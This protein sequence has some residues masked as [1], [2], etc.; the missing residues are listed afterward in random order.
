MATAFKIKGRVGTLSVRNSSGIGVEEFLDVAEG[1]SIDNATFDNIIH[2]APLAQFNTELTQRF[3][4][5]APLPEDALR[6]ALNALANTPARGSEERVEIVKRS[7]LW[8]HIQGFE[9][10]LSIASSL[11]GLAQPLLA[12]LSA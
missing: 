1:A 7:R 4:L 8:K 5:S 3:K 10:G 12:S 2:V 11:A 6:D 9:T